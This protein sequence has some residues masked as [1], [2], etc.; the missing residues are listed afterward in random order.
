VH[1]QLE[2]SLQRG[3]DGR[4]ADLASGLQ[5][6]W[7]SRNSGG[8]W[9]PAGGSASG[10]PLTLSMVT[11]SPLATRSTGCRRASK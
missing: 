9:K 5:R 3:F 1:E 7:I 8:T 4:G 10:P 6:A 11:Q 2:A